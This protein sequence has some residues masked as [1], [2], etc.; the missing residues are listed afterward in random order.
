VIELK[1]FQVK[2]DNI[3]FFYKNRFLVLPLSEVTFVNDVPHV[4]DE[5]IESA[6]DCTPALPERVLGAAW[7]AGIVFANEVT[8][9]WAVGIARSCKTVS[10]SEI[11]KAFLD[12]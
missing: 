3:R 5:N 10:G 1:E 2:G 11:I 8:P 9:D 4:H 7:R 12:A 6:Y